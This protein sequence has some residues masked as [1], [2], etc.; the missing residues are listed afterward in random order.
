MC[1]LTGFQIE[2]GAIRPSG[3]LKVEYLP[4]SSVNKSA[5]YMLRNAQNK[6]TGQLVASTNWLNLPALPTNRQASDRS[7]ES[8]QGEAS[9]LEYSFDMPAATPAQIRELHLMRNQRFLLRVT[10]RSKAQ[11]LVGDFAEGM[12]FN[13]QLTSGTTATG[14]NVSLSFR[15]DTHTPILAL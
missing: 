4:I 1:D 3:I 6:F 7:Q 15:A 13:Y 5:S 11:Y 14:G 10:D 9:E 8:E 2:C 12:N